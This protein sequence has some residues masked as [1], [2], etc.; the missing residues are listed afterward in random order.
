MFFFNII[1]KNKLIFFF[2]LI[3][4]IYNSIQIYQYANDKYAYQYGDWL[5]NYS[6]GYYDGWIDIT[7]NDNT[8]SLI[9]L[10]GLPACGKTTYYNE[11]IDNNYK[12]YDD[13]ISDIYDGNLLKDI[14][15]NVKICISD[16]R[17]CNFN[18]F[19]QIMKEVE[20]YITKDKIK[21]ILFRNNKL[22]SLI[23]ASKRNKKNVNNM[24]EMYSSIYKIENYLNYNHLLLS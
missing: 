14:K 17:L 2:L 6:N 23:N 19:E 7:E 21:L 10:I 3:C 18:T 20:K 4:F 8:I 1:K 13:F 16:P 15:N 9:I 24:I 11:V 12:F 5:I 22:S